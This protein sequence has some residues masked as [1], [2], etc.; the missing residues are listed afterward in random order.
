MARLGWYL[1]IER[2]IGQVSKVQRDSSIGWLGNLSDS[3]NSEAMRMAYL[4]AAGFER[5]IGKDPI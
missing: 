3:G 5:G 1:K 2:E 4:V